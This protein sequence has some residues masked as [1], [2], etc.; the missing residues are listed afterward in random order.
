MNT[1]KKQPKVINPKFIVMVMHP[2]AKKAKRYFGFR[3]KRAKDAF[4]RR[5]KK[6]NEPYPYLIAMEVDHAKRGH[7]VVLVDEH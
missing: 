4:L 1:T 6:L 7:P 2:A 5:I 3:T